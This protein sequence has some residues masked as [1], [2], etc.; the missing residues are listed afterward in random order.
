MRIEREM[1]LP[2][3]LSRYPSCRRIFDHYGLTGCGG[4]RG[5]R[6]TVAFFARA[7]QVDQERLLRELDQAAQQDEIAPGKLVYEPS[8]ADVI[9]RGFFKAGIVVMFTA[10][11]VFGGINLA[12]LAG[13]GELAALDLRAS[14]WAHAH[15]QI[16]G[17]VTLF[18]MGFAYQAFPRFKL[19]KLWAPR[20]ASGTLYVMAAALA[21][22]T[23]AGLFDQDSLWQIVGIV[24]GVA[25][26]A[27]VLGFIVIVAKT[28]AQSEQSR[29]PYEKYIYAALGWMLLGFVADLAVFIASGSIRGERAWIQFIGLYDAPWRD[30][31][32]IGFAGGM[33]LGV[34]QRFL[35]FIYGAREVP[36]ATSRL[37]FWLWNGS[38]ILHMA[39]YMALFQTRE[40][41]YALGWELGAAG[42][43]VSM[44]LLARA[45]GLFRKIE[46]ADRSLPFIRAAYAWGIF[47][48]ALLMLLPI[49]SRAVGTTFSHAFFGAYRHAFTVGFIS[50]MIVGVSSKVAPVLAGA[51]VTRLNSL[52]LAFWLINIG[53]VMRV[54]FQILTD[55][56]GWAFPLMALSAWV[57]IT[58]LSIWAVDL[59]R[60]M[61]AKPSLEKAP[62]DGEISA[63]RKVFDVITR[64]PETEPV[65]LR[66]GFSLIT[67]PAA[68]RVFARSISLAQACRLKGVPQD[69]FIHDL[70]QTTALHQR[71][72]ANPLSELVTIGVASSPGGEQ[73]DQIRG[74]PGGRY[75]L[76]S[77]GGGDDPQ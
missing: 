67:N 63:T 28:L 56:F 26:L 41:I 13:R 15:A 6:E 74:T 18:V 57:E 23:L 44:A 7:H 71:H 51:D 59:W 36:A 37:V 50:M 31:Q 52:R 5:P 73:R 46:E 3:V 54:G 22:R 62:S 45:F 75:D 11:C 43:L 58:G 47:S 32:L 29:Q 64:Y 68:R 30:I 27:V 38:L 2:D 14:I 10:G 53:S 61:S 55:L 66:Y 16:A 19:T 9:Y 1:L 70:R 40:P 25:E 33:I 42:M 17:W 39:S 21:V 76:Q 60:T 24:A 4:P 48:F 72:A 49:Y 35:P 77:W 69:E 8:P 12:L 34:S 20:L 65:F